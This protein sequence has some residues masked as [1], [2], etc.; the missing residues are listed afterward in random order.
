MFKKILIAHR[1]DSGRK[2]VAAQTEEGRRLFEHR[3]CGIRRRLVQ[4]R[5]RE[6]KIARLARVDYKPSRE[7][8]NQCVRAGSTSRIVG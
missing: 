7:R 1:G 6:N 3:G 8:E 4:N 5:H 2:A